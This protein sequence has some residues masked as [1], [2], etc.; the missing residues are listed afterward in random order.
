MSRYQVER[1]DNYIAWL[2]LGRNLTNNGQ[3]MVSLRDVQFDDKGSV[4]YA[5]MDGMDIRSEGLV[6]DFVAKFQQVN[7][8]FEHKF[9]DDFKVRFAAGRSMSRWDGPMRLQTFIDAIDVDNVSLDFRGNRETP[10]ITFGNIDVSN[11]ASF[12]YAPALAD[13]TIL[14]GFSTQGKPSE[15]ITD[16]NTFELSG[17]WQ[18]S[19]MFGGKLGAQLRENDFNSHVSNLYPSY[20]PVTALPAGVTLADITTHITGLDSKFGSGAPADWVAVDSKKWREVFNFDSYPFCGTECGANKNS[21][22]ERVK[23]AYVM[24][25]FNSGDAWSHALRADLGV[26]YVKTDQNAMGYIPVAAPMG[27]PFPTVGQR[28]DV[29]RSYTDTLPSLNAVFEMTPDLL[30]RLSASKVMARADLGSLTPT[31]TI[32]ATTRTGTVNNPFLDPIRAKTADL[33][34]E[35]YFAPG[36]L[37]SAAYFYKDIETYIQRQTVIQPYNE[38]G[39][40]PELLAGTPSSPTDLFTVSRLLNTPGGPLKGFELNAQVPFKFLPGFWSN[41]GV[42]ANYTRTESTITYILSATTPPVDND[43]VGLSK[44]SASSTLFYDDGK[45]SIRFTG[46]YR[47]KYIRGI[48]AS[49]GSDLQGNKANLFVDASASWVINDNFT[50]ILEAQNLTDERNVLFIDSSRE[51]T[52]FETEIGRTFNLGATFKF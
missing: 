40:P 15:N 21:I 18:F 26:R 39:L 32:T 17:D 35:W 2:S 50:M 48:P 49:P 41:F 3:P 33:G 4:Q 23:S 8:E 25:N 51:D 27:A 46:S 47:D 38:L 9:N 31:A 43:L 22:D 14:G 19:K 44:N 36:S 12:Q 16:I 7:M 45:F 20:V 37:L 13:G 30:L 29:D 52:L 11:P 6:D 1:R 28:N 5:V 24:F 42:L 10:L 34:I